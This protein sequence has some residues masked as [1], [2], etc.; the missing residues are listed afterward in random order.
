MPDAPWTGAARADAA[1]TAAPTAPPAA[2]ALRD[3]LRREARAVGACFYFHPDNSDAQKIALYV[4]MALWAVAGAGV[5]FDRVA[6]DTPE[7]SALW[8]LLTGLM[9]YL[10]GRT[11]GQEVTHLQYAPHRARRRN[12]P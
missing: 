9:T 4:A 6:I 10:F 8:T 3:R 2:S 1:D 5:L 12:D 7:K 11:H